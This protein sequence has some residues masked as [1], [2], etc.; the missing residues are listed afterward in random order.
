MP[1]SHILTSKDGECGGHSL[2]YPHPL[3]RI[4][5]DSL[6]MTR[7]SESR[8]LRFQTMLWIRRCARTGPSLEVAA[9]CQADKN[10]A[11]STKMFRASVHVAG[12]LCIPLMLIASIAL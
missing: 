1:D 4:G 8:R 10:G 7:L 6:E 2:S 9:H 12:E 3:A 5:A 11:N